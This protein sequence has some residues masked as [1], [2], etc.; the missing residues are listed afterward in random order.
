MT[1]QDDTDDGG[2]SGGGGRTISFGGFTVTIPGTGGGGGSDDGDDG[3]TRTTTPA[4]SPDDGGGGGEPSDTPPAAPNASSGGGGGG[5]EPSDTPDVD[6]DAGGGGGGGGGGTVSAPT[7]SSGGGS[8]E[9]DPTRSAPTPGNPA[10]TGQPTPA[11]DEQPEPDVPPEP[12]TPP[13]ETGRGDIRDR[14]STGGGGAGVSSPGS[15]SGGGGRREGPP[16]VTE[17]GQVD[18]AEPLPPVREQQGIETGR[19]PRADRARDVEQFVTAADRPTQRRELARERIRDRVPEAEDIDLQRTGTEG[20][21]RATFEAG[22]EQRESLAFAPTPEDV[23]VTEDLGVEFTESARQRLTEAQREAAERN[24]VNQSPFIDRDDVAVTGDQPENFDVSVSDESQRERIA[25]QSDRISEEDIARVFETEEGQVRGAL[26][27]EARERLA[28][29]QFEERADVGSNTVAA[30]PEPIDRFDP[31]ELVFQTRGDTVEVRPTDQ[32]QREFLREQVA[33]RDDDISPSDVQVQEQN[34]EFVATAEVSESELERLQEFSQPQLSDFV[35]RDFNPETGEYE[36]GLAFDEDDLPMADSGA[37]SGVAA[38]GATAVAVP[39]PTTSAG[40]A[41]V[42]GGLGTAAIAEETLGDG[43]ILTRTRRERTSAERMAA[44]ASVQGGPVSS[45]LDVREPQ[46]SEIEVGETQVDELTVDE[47]A[48]AGGATASQSELE[49]REP[50]QR[51]LEPR[52]QQ[53]D[54]LPLE[55]AEEPDTGRSREQTARRDDTVVPEDFPLPGRDVPADRTQEFVRDREPVDIL[56]ELAPAAQ[57]VGRQREQIGE[58]EPDRVRR[59]RQRRRDRELEEILRGPDDDVF[60]GRR[61]LPRREFPTGRGAVVGLAEEA[62][63][64]EV[65]VDDPGTIERSEFEQGFAQ[66]A[67]TDTLLGADQRGRQDALGLQG[68]VERVDAAQ[69]A[70]VAQDQ[71]LRQEQRLEQE[72]A[73][74]QA[75]ETEQ[76]AE[77]AE[78]TATDVAFQEELA[79]ENVFAERPVE[80]RRRIPGWRFGLPEFEGDQRDRTDESIFGSQGIFD[81]RIADVDELSRELENPFGPEN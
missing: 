61:R 27:D 35:T 49:V 33:S 29:E 9:P 78:L 40:G 19:G 45:E 46:Q 77:T 79:T 47:Q 48:A 4:P 24:V 32:A 70:G 73:F 76:A 72:L 12:P 34:G 31:D 23:R 2:D 54:E 65:Q 68:A 8:S 64:P 74:D 1:H 16:V 18:E 36:M 58:R 3:D 59:E 67:P 44:E 11:G 14:G 5:G 21:F 75:L 39:E 13:Q 26:T 52:E 17:R 53:V 28:R 20:V 62:Q 60:I 42:L 10:G 43:D 81:T 51:E 22:G 25:A 71:A 66:R 50:R 38:A 15:V 57:Q 69:R 7:P 37:A 56:T 6:I 41:L 63:E 80:R 55:P 30:A